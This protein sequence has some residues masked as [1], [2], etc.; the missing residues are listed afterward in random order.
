MKTYLTPCKILLL[1]S[2]FKIWLFVIVIVVLEEAIDS[3]DCKLKPYLSQ[4]SLTILLGKE[5]T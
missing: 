2:I 4:Q 3:I 5:T 1:E